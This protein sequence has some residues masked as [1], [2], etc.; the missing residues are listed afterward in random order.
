MGLKAYVLHKNR[1][2]KE[3]LFRT[4]MDQQKAM[5]GD[6]PNQGESSQYKGITWQHF[7]NTL[8]LAS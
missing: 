4:Q 6:T 3:P 2:T 5:F 1:E 7:S 8:T